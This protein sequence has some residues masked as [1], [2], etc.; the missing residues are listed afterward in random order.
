MTPSWSFRPE[1]QLDAAARVVEARV[2]HLSRYRA[3]TF[4]GGAAMEPPL[5]S[6]IRCS[7]LPRPLTFGLGAATACRLS[8]WRA[9][10]DAIAG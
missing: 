9:A 10:A 2:A 5:S 6:D 1:A 3:A 4:F 7:K 8:T